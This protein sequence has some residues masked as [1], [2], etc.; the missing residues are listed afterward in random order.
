M[1][2]NRGND[3]DHDCDYDDDYDDDAALLM[4]AAVDDCYATALMYDPRCIVRH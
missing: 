3:H 2:I 1:M 4:G